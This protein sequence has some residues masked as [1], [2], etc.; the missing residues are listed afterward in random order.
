[1]P[2]TEQTWRDSKLLHVVFGLSSLAML[3][4]T[5]WMLAVD[6]R[7]EWKD[8][9]RKFRDVETWTAQSRIDEQDTSDYEKRKVELE[10][11]L[12]K[13]RAEVPEASQIDA[14]VTAA[15]HYAGPNGYDVSSV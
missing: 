8:V 12:A 3:V 4:T 10:R 6:H 1:M 9:Q 7:R 13:V 14:F 15:K 5:V 11:A 2:A